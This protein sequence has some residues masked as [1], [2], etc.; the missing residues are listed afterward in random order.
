MAPPFSLLSA[1]WIPVKRADGSRDPI[2][3]HEITSDHDLNPIVSFAWP[4]PDFDLAAHEFLIGLFAV[5]FPPKGQRDWLHYFHIPPTPEELREVFQPYAAAFSLDGEGPRFLQDFSPLEA[6]PSPVEALFIEAPGAHTV[7]LNRDLLVKSGRICVLSRASAAMALYTLQQ[8]APSGGSRISHV[9][10]RW[11][12]FGDAGHAGR[13]GKWP[14]IG[15]LAE[16]LAPRSSI[17]A[18]RS[19]SLGACLSLARADQNFGEGRKRKC[20]GCRPIASFL[21]HAAP[22]PAYFRNEPGPPALRSDG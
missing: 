20:F 1:K 3:P 10:T 6:E 7:K 16:A 18:A 15:A 4:R 13:A 8:F 9:S 17:E 14:G 22:H 11:R 5:A 19:S 21:R 2:A 12:A